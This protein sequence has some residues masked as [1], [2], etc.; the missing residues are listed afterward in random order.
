MIYDPKNLKKF[1]HIAFATYAL[2]GDILSHTLNSAQ[3]INERQYGNV[4]MVDDMCMLDFRAL[5]PDYYLSAHTTP[6]PREEIAPMQ[7]L[8]SG[9]SGSVAT[10]ESVHSRAL[11]AYTKIPDASLDGKGAMPLYG[12][13]SYDKQG[14]MVARHPVATSV[15]VYETTLI[16][17][18]S[19]S[20]TSGI[21]ASVATSNAMHETVIVPRNR[22]PPTWEELEKL[23]TDCNTEGNRLRDGCKSVEKKRND[24][25]ESVQ[26]KVTEATQWLWSFWWIPSVQ[27]LGIIVMLM[28]AFLEFMGYG[29]SKTRIVELVVGRCCFVLVT[30]NIYRPESLF[31]NEGA[32]FV[33]VYGH[34]HHVIP[35]Y[36]ILPLNCLTLL[37]TKSTQSVEAMLTLSSCLYGLY[38][39]WS[40]DTAGVKAKALA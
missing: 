4:P 22:G 17:T 15:S 33:L 7:G 24:I 10:S 21:Y 11:V 34:M 40:R 27:T 12:D 18:D 28:A 26:V 6:I 25:A 36:I 8:P 30:V 9:H 1:G 14:E 2:F 39:W 5:L 35:Q 31:Q 16:A 20:A 38:Q 19:T 32:F 37:Y 13:L 3:G 23:R 29:G